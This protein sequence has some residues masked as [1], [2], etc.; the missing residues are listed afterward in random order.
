M[1]TIVIDGLGLIGGSLAM[2][3]R[4]QWPNA[5]I[6][7]VDPNQMSLEF[8]KGQGIIDDGCDALE[9]IARQA[10]F[11]ILAT[12][13]DLILAHLNVLSQLKLKRDTIVTDVGSTKKEI[14]EQ[15]TPLIH[16][17]ISFIG[18]H[19]MAGSQR[20]GIHAARSDLFQEANYFLIPHDEDIIG[21]QAV[22][23][24]TKLL[25][26]LGV[27]WKR[28]SAEVHDRIVGQLSHLPHILAAGLVNRTKCEAEQMHFPMQYASS[29]FKST[30]RIAASDPQMWTA[31]LQSNSDI[32]IEDIERFQSYLDEVKTALQKGDMDYICRYF[33]QAKAIRTTLDQD[34]TYNSDRFR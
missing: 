30:T 29:G 9:D 31:I 11:I 28:L 17:G 5:K 2:G 20:S 33:R 15:S 6:Y 21:E 14:M 22:E 1:K 4:K 26:G 16:Q 13:V 3:I 23:Q 10:D 8:A 25:N 7:A 19:P 34:K 18:G 27:C 32:L 12:S 24:I